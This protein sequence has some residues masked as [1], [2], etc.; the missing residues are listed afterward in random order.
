LFDFTFSLSKTDVQREADRA[1]I[2]DYYLIMAVGAVK[3]DR[4]KNVVTGKR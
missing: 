3:S 1:Q 4:L 2:E